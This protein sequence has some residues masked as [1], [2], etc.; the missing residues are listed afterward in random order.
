MTQRTLTMFVARVS[1]PVS[2][3][4]LV[5]DVTL[6]SEDELS[7]SLTIVLRMDTLVTLFLPTASIMFIIAVDMI[8]T[9]RFFSSCL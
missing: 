1:L 6:V 2:S 5:S 7:L 8:S 4:D 3:V 9:T